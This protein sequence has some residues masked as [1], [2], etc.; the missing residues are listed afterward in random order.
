MLVSDIGGA[1]DIDADRSQSVTSAW[2]ASHSSFFMV[3]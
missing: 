3:T 1:V 2:Q